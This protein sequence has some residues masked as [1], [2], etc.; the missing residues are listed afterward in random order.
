MN[1]DK[2]IVGIFL[3]ISIYRKIIYMKTYNIKYPLKDNVSTNTYFLM[4]QV[5]KDAFSSDLL[6]LLL[7]QKGERYY[8]PNYGTNLLKYIFE[9]NDGITASDVEQEIKN[10]VSLFIPA[11]KITKINFNW[12]Y[13]DNGQPI[14]ENQLNVNIQFAYTEDTFTENGEL[15]LNF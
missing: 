7:T 3:F 5:T 14:S 8:E 6:L 11:L 9:Q 13:D 4:T 12:N 2:L 10:T 1:P 15:D